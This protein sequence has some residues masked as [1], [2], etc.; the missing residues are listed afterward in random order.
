M[1]QIT[2][3][4]QQKKLCEPEKSIDGFLNQRRTFA[5]NFYLKRIMKR[6]YIKNII[7]IETINV[8]FFQEN[9]NDKYKFCVTLVNLEGY[10]ANILLQLQSVTE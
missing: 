2:K 6:Q 9:V 3:Q 4:S 10:V 1:A 5:S 8:N 7:N